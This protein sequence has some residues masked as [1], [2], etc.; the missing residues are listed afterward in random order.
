[1]KL[2]RNTSSMV[3]LSGIAGILAASCLLLMSRIFDTPLVISSK[4]YQSIVGD[5]IPALV[6]E[7]LT[8]TQMSTLVHAEESYI[9]FFA[10]PNCRACDEV[11]PIL[12]QIAESVSVLMITTS[13]SGMI[14]KDKEL[15]FEF[16]V[17]VDTLAT[18]MNM[19]GIS[20]V[21]T[22]IHVDEE[23]QIKRIAT[24]AGLGT[25]ALLRLVAE[26]HQGNL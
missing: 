15:D 11:Y 22:A 12:N 13:R 10:S 6:L 1:M 19:L 23:G 2:T 25:R 14:E 18:T 4:R 20:S 26:E 7:D 3:I 16:P 17:L 21:P 24:G 5:A 8:G 9:V